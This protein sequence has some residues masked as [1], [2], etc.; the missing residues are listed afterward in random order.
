MPNSE[1]TTFLNP[2]RAQLTTTD[3]KPCAYFAE[4]DGRRVFVKGP[5]IDKSHAMVPKLVHQF[6]SLFSNL[7]LA[8]VNV[9]RFFPDGMADCQFGLRMSI[10]KSKAHYF[11]I[12][13]DIISKEVDLATRSRS[14]PKAWPTPVTVVDWSKLKHYSHVEYNKSY[15]KT[16]YKTDVD[17]AY[18]FAK[19][20]ILSWVCGAGVDMSYSNFIYDKEN[21]SVYQVGHDEWLKF[22]WAVSSTRVGST[23][24]KAWSHL[25]KFIKSNTKYFRS[26]FDSLVDDQ[27]I[28]KIKSSFCEHDAAVLEERLNEVA[29]DW[30]VIGAVVLTTS[31]VYKKRKI[32]EDII[33]EK[34]PKLATP[35]TTPVTTAVIP[36]FIGDLYVGKSTCTNLMTT[37]PWGF[38]VTSR[39][40]DMQQAIRRGNFE[41]AMVSF[42]SCTNLVRIY[43]DDPIAT[44][45]YID[46]LN[47]VVVCAVEDI[48]VANM[49]LVLYTIEVLSNLTTM[50]YD[51]NVIVVTLARIIYNLCVSHK[52]QIQCHMTHVYHPNNTSLAM[53]AGITSHNQTPTSFSDPNWFRYVTTDP[54]KLWHYLTYRQPVLYEFYKKMPHQHKVPVLQFALA[55]EYFRCNGNDCSKIAWCYNDYPKSV[56]VS[57]MCNNLIQMDPQDYARDNFGEVQAR[58]LSKLQD[59][60]ANTCLYNES[61]VFVNIT[62][63]N[64]FIESN[65]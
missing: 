8:E 7:S 20:I 57:D 40:N 32:V 51:K 38:S 42:C 25:E 19:H 15:S 4:M 36:E 55:I 43:P 22:D 37:D 41:Q 62:F 45:V 65:V 34:K 28:D 2:L 63:K 3:S 58:P 24:T 50:A 39:K 13:N 33:C 47:H 21:H 5:Y 11:Q 52:T 29:A 27:L 46:M 18:M 14:T 49:S 9:D 31:G 35:E 10:D 54:D 56:K 48:G 26:F 12:A 23:N 44:K 16:I 61:T 6:K 64:I 53:K 30:T 17:A 1:S 59:K 60:K